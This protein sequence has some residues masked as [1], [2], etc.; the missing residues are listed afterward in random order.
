MHFGI[1][2]GIAPLPLPLAFI[3]VF[4]LYLWLAPWASA[5]LASKLIHII[6]V[7]TYLSRGLTHA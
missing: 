1:Y 2:S 7:A 3:L 4:A 5:F 6:W